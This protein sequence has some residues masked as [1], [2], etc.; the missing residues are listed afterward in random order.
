MPPL[1][2]DLE[3]N[4]VAFD[5]RTTDVFFMSVDEDLYSTYLII[6]DLDTIKLVRQ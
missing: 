3:L 5:T 2:Y 4:G 1:I 6:K